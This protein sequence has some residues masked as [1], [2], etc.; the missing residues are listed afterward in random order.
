[1]KEFI[2]KIFGSVGVVVLLVAYVFMGCEGNSSYYV[3][4]QDASTNKAIKDARITLE[5]NEGFRKERYTDDDGRAPLEISGYNGKPGRLVVD[6]EGFVTFNR[7]VTLESRGVPDQI[8]LTP[9]TVTPAPTHTHTPTFTPSPTP[10]PSLS[11]TPP[12]TPTPTPTDTPTPTPTP[13]PKEDPCGYYDITLTT[14]GSSDRVRAA[15][16]YV[17]GTFEE[18]PPDR[19]LVLFTYDFLEQEYWAEDI[20]ADVREEE[21]TWHGS[22]LLKLPGRDKYQ[23]L[24]YFFDSDGQSWLQEEGV[25]ANGKT[26]ITGDLP[27]SAKACKKVTVYIDR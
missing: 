25:E 7:F 13:D 9:G 27:K 16:I 3:R 23:I 1:M 22:V 24:I 14:P 18:K 5:G 4:V 6:K 19:S 2:G 26:R 10:T 15:R 21:K 11:P 8:K 20:V 12:P 17:S